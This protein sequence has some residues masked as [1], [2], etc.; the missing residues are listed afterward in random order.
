MVAA[1][2]AF[3]LPGVA[4][5]DYKDRDPVPV[6]VNTLTPSG[7]QQLK[8]VLPYDYYR[9]ELH[10]CAPTNKESQGESLGSILFGDRLYN[11]PFDLRMGVNEK[12]GVLCRQTIPKEDAKFINE[13]IRENY[14][15]NWLV[16]G[17]PAATKKKD[18]KRP[19]TVVRG[20]PLSTHLAASAFC[21]AARSIRLLDG[22]GDAGP[23]QAEQVFYSV[24]FALGDAGG[25]DRTGKLLPSK[26]GATLAQ[27]HFNNHYDIL[28]LFHTEKK[29][30]KRIVGVLVWP[31][32]R[33]QEA[34][35]SGNVDCGS[36]SSKPLVLDE[37]KDTDI[38]YTYTVRWTE[39]PATTWATRWDN[40]LHG[41]D[42]RIHWFSLVNSVIIVLFL[43]GMV[44]MI[45]L[46]ALHKDIS[47]YNQ[48][49]AQEDVQEDSGWKL[50]HGDVFRPPANPMLLSVMAGTG[51]QLFCMAVVTLVFAVLGFLSPSNRGMLAT[52]MI[53]FYLVFAYVAG[54][55]SAQMYKM[56][57]GEAWKKNV[58][59]EQ[60]EG[61][62]Q[63][64]T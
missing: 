44:A 9:R 34:D 30:A 46:R 48:I 51:A 29:D 26:N 52:V 64:E 57:G 60:P 6:L 18:H 10:F 63:D 42:P 1:A 61:F 62:V 27:P 35:V 49:D 3:Y 19:G 13:R 17:L 40:Y 24:G 50:V 28:I 55:V 23:K 5:T 21:R 22:T 53:L 43:T 45:L 56:F 39:D 59:M 4:P 20:W 14:A 15:I 58:I 16:D 37:T 36:D 2:D 54:Y 11:S 47:R 41:F 32:S 25:K 7:S 8:S 33:V 31:A 38:Y 12:C